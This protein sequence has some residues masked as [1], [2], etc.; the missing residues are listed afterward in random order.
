[1]LPLR[2]LD[3]SHISTLY[4]FCQTKQA[5]VFKYPLG[6]FAFYSLGHMSNFL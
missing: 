6:K 3:A 1:M 5:E 2:Y 4:L